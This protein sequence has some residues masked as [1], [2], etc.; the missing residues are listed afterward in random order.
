[1][2]THSQDAAAAAAASMSGFS[3]TTY[4]NSVFERLLQ[5]NRT[6]NGQIGASQ[7]VAPSPLSGDGGTVMNQQDLFSAQIDR[8]RMLAALQQQ[9]RQLAA[10]MAHGRPVLQQNIS[11]DSLGAQRFMVDDFAG[12]GNLLSRSEQD[13]LLSRYPAM[14]VTGH[15]GLGGHSD[16]DFSN[17]SKIAD[18]LLAKQVA[19]HEASKPRTSRLPCQARGM[20]ADHNSSVR[21]LRRSPQPYTFFSMDL[22][23][24]FVSHELFMVV[25]HCCARLP[26]LRFLM[27]LVTDNTCCV[28][29]HHVALLGLSSVT[30]CTARSRSQSRTSD[31]VIC[32]P[33]RTSTTTMKPPQVRSAR[34]PKHCHPTARGPPPLAPLVPS[35]QK[36]VRTLPI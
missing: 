28:P 30:A 17:T 32:I 35:V 15:I 31:P 26:S 9:Q 13:M 10:T 19:F 34:V 16:L 14:A 33:S 23:L 11:P 22:C 24:F 3:G 6:V 7:G 18:L 29:I 27:M 2:N 1:M 12:A 36:P 25:C 4:S 5:Q 8:N 21:L 20:K